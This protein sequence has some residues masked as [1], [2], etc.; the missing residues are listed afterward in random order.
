[1]PDRLAA[2]LV[3]GGKLDLTT[4]QRPDRKPAALDA[5]DELAGKLEIKRVAVFLSGARG[6]AGRFPFGRRFRLD[7]RASGPDSVWALPDARPALRRDVA[8][9]ALIAV[10]SE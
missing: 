2:Y 1:V 8:V 3:N 5:V 6:L 10:P 9:L 7:A 4:Q